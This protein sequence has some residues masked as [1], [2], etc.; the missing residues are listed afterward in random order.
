[1]TRT[2]NTLQD[3]ANLLLEHSVEHREDLLLEELDRATI[4]YHN[5]WEI[6]NEVRPTS[7]M[8]EGIGD[9]A[10]GPDSLAWA[11][12]YERFMAEFGILLD[13]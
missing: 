7:F 2:N 10:T 3:I 13:N 6:I 9:Y 1:M 12:L 4:Y 11:I 5:C 8:V